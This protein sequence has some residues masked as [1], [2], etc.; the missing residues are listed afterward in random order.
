MARAP[1]YLA[2]WGTIRLFASDIHTDNGRTQVV[3]DLASGDQ[4]PV[5]DRGLRVKRARVSLL[6]DEFQ[7]AEEPAVA[8]ARFK[9]AVD[10]GR[11][12]VFT[13]P[14]EEQSYIASVGEF[15]HQI[16]G[17]NVI[18]ATAEFIAEEDVESVS[19]SGAAA[20]GVAGE[21]SVLQTS[22][23][24]DEELRALDIETST[25]TSLDPLS[26]EE[27]REFLADPSCPVT[28]DAR[29]SVTSWTTGESVATRQVLVDAA[30]ISEKIAALIEINQ[31][32]FDLALW[33]A[34]R[35]SILL[36]ES[37]RSAA[38]SVTSETPSVFVMRIETTTALLPLAA[39]IYGGAAAQDRA[40]Q[41]AA[42][43][44]ISTP[45]WLHPGDYV[46]PTRSSS[47][48]AGR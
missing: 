7:G 16:D 13:H 43:N 15:E 46:M 18:T 14:L 34:F 27:V 17:S 12:L 22:H 40:R 48:R 41:I 10:A 33:P 32:E 36:G 21:L 9:A 19:P 23:A 45:A 35:A 38:I 29:A 6:F 4:H 5:Q 31:L 2:S 39:R 28:D 47:E 30:R 42:L 20:S 8:F 44:D 26:D 24:L 37:V 3:H 11:R 25:R 1:L